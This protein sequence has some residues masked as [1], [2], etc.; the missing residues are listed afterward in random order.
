MNKDQKKIIIIGGGIAGL[1]AGIYAQNAGFETHIYEKNAVAG[2]ECM[3]WN[4]RGHHIDNCIHWLTGT[5]PG[6]SLRKVW[7]DLGAL[8]PDTE[9]AAGDK[10]YTFSHEG[11]SATLWKDLDRTEREFLELAPEDADEIKKFIQHVRYA[12]CCEMPVEKPMDMMSVADYIQ[13]GKS[14]A[15]MPKVM[16]EYGKINLEDFSNRFQNPMLRML[17]CGYM[18]K[19]YTAHSFI[20]SYA[21]MASGNGE[22]PKGGSLAMV[23]RMIERFKSLGGTLHLNCPVE[24]VLIE[25]KNAIGIKLADETTA[26]A[27]YIISATDTNEL[28]TRLIGEQ[29]MSKEWKKCYSNMEDYPLFSGFQMAFSV[30]RDCY[31]ETGTVLFDCAPLTVGA[32]PASRMSVKSFEYEPGFAPSHKMVLQSNFV[33]NDADYFYWKSLGRDEYLAKK[34]ELCREVTDRILVQF[35][36]LNG[37]IELLDCWSPLTYE[38]YCNAYHGAYMSFITKKDVKAFKVKGVVKGLSNVLIASQWVMAPGGLPVAAAAGKFAV[39]RILKAEKR[40]MR[41]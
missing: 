10:F 37:H 31:N 16:K 13:L 27:D 28:F 6:T 15:N 11:K 19:E 1:S 38:R 20:V 39:Q 34:E 9:F 40:E 8:S 12:F 14:M 24:K 33:Q 32:T 17:F 4:R 41:L 29:Y 30:D 7:E 26:P 3:G 25:G 22:V 23:N 18:P 5:K 35:P 21:T 2:G 36:K